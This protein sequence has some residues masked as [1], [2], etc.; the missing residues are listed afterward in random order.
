[1]SFL[2][3]DAVEGRAAGS[4][5]GEKAARYLAGELERLGLVPLGEGG[6]YQ[7]VPL[8]AS[9]PEPSNQLFLVAECGSGPLRPEEEYLIEAGGSATL[10]P[11]P[12]NVVFAGHG[13]VAPEFD[14]NDYQD[15]DVSGK[16]VAVLSGEP[17][18]DLGRPGLLPR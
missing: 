7:P 13:I 1:M 6:F 14:Y 10:L 16:V 15:I 3:A 2:G 5:G 11:Q 9:R 18:S 17:P 8:H 4:E 12:T